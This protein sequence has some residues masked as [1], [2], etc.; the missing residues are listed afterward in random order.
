MFK[1][2]P[3]SPTLFINQQMQKMIAD[4]K[5][6]YKFGFGESPFSP[7]QMVAEALA[8]AV[9]RTEYA[10]LKG[11]T[12]LRS[13]IVEHYKTDQHI[14]FDK[15]DIMVAPGSKMLLF[16]I[17]MAF[18]EATVLL[19]QPS[20]VSYAPQV[21]LAGHTVLGIPT[22]FDEK[23][24]I[25]ADSLEAVLQKERRGE[26]IL[27]LNNPGNPDGLSFTES[28]L[29]A[30]A[31]VAKKHNIWVISDEIYGLLNHSENHHCFAKYY[32]KTFTTSGL[33]KW[34]GAGGWRFGFVALSNAIP[35][36]CKV[37]L[38]GIISETYS[39][40]T[41]PVQV[42]AHTAYNNIPVFKDYLTNQLNWLRT[43]GRYCQEKMNEV[44]IACHPPEGGFYL[45]PDF[46]FLKYKL[47]QIDSS[48][49][50]CQLL[51]KE[52]GVAVLPGTAFGVDKDIWVV[53]MAY[54]DFDEKD[55][56]GENPTKEDFP[57]IVEGMETLVEWVE[58]V[59]KC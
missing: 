30:L 10:N 25:T 57:R 22:N 58:F 33:S 24:H 50:F 20:W 5:K 59:K 12:E 51:L 31:K 39:C 23:W 18:E 8:S 48:D 40:T 34:C 1:Q 53:R 26:T 56:Q 19:P 14:L 6:V 4:G 54:V 49:A 42:A 15:E 27:I 16:S 7:P 41:V 13:S 45:F 11:L 36:E 28:E 43:V 2:T 37:A 3:I 46:S 35:N 52:T 38:L 29:T 55:L 32:D 44:G 47:P 21:S 9:S 17:L